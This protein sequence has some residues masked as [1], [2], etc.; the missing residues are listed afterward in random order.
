[1]KDIRLKFYTVD[2]VNILKY[3]RSL[4]LENLT[5]GSFLYGVHSPLR[6]FSSHYDYANNNKSSSTATITNTPQPNMMAYQHYIHTYHNFLCCPDP[7]FLSSH[8][9]SHSY[10]PYSSVYIPLSLSSQTSSHRQSYLN[11]LK[12]QELREQTLQL[13]EI[14]S[15]LSEM[16]MK[17]SNASQDIQYQSEKRR[18]RLE[19]LQGLEMNGIVDDYEDEDDDEDNTNNKLNMYGKYKEVVDEDDVNYYHD[20]TENTNIQDIY[21]YDVTEIYQFK[22]NPD[23]DHINNN[24]RKRNQEQD[25][26]NHSLQL[27]KQQQL[28][29]Q[30]Q[31]QLEEEEKERQRRL[32]IMTGNS[33]RSSNR[34]SQYIQSIDRDK[35]SNNRNDKTDKTD[36]GYGYN[37]NNSDITSMKELLHFNKIASN[38]MLNIKTDDRRNY[39]PINDHVSSDNSSNKKEPKKNAFS[40][41]SSSSS[42]LLST[43]RRVLPPLYQPS[44]IDTTTG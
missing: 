7:P 16:E 11:K 1:M 15:R 25:P 12:S 3:I 8:P 35:Y 6:E 27:K 34:Y 20:N 30:Q 18:S 40:Q 42:L 23:S 31:Q 22:T 17:V 36:N 44:S 10:L 32:A 41:S 9:P 29:L 26:N 43:E 13:Q 24:T 37:N 39:E 5:Q 28:L 21:Q 14:D 2:A 4:C 33:L 38:T 19:T